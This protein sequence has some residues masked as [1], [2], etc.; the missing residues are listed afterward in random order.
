MGA[1]MNVKLWSDNPSLDDLIGIADDIATI[2]AEVLQGDDHPVTVGIEGQ[3]GSGKTTILNIIGKK[4]GANRSTVAVTTRPWEYDPLI[5]PKAT[6]IAEVLAAIHLAATQNRQVSERVKRKFK[7]L[8]KRIRVSKAVK[9]AASSAV[10]GLPQVADFF[11]L[12]KEDA[13]TVSDPTLHGFRAEFAELM[14]ELHDT[15]HLVVVLVDDLDR[16]LPHTVIDVLEAIKLFLSVD[17][18][19]FI[20]AADHRAVAHAVAIKYEPSPHAVNLGRQYSEKIIQIP[21]AVPRLDDA[22]A[23]L[24]L[25]SLI[26][27]RHLGTPFEGARLL[28]ECKD[29]PGSSGELLNKLSESGFDR[30]AKAILKVVDV[31]NEFAEGNPRRLKRFLNAYSMRSAIMPSGLGMTPQALV[32]WM[33]LEDCVPESFEQLLIGWRAGNLSEDLGVLV[34]QTNPGRTRLM[35]RW[36]QMHP[37]W[38]DL[39]ADAYL[40]LAANRHR[41]PISE[42]N[43]PEKVRS[44]AADRMLRRVDA[45]VEAPDGQGD[46]TFEL[47]PVLNLPWANVDKRSLKR[48]NPDGGVR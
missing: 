17:R 11:E 27:Q 3:W 38:T 30:H 21:V 32:K 7:A 43:M 39:Q 41:L 13:E 9:L 47:G 8:A 34:S 22:Q 37:P 15:V 44:E 40:P 33:V 4:I 1:S 23:Q 5:D 16:C 29:S 42:P 19:A 28:Q 12:F 46:G 6:L 26:T 45:T 35:S 36:T 24:Y 10:T 14:R 20:V 48:D 31:L 18:M 2:V 25:A